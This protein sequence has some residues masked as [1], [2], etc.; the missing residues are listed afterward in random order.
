MGRDGVL[1]PA[2]GRLDARDQPAFAVG[3]M[4]AI[5][6]A[7][8]LG[9]A[10]SPTIRAA[11]EFVLNGTA[12]FLGVLFLLSAAA[13]V[14]I[15]ARTRAA[16]VDGVVLPAFATLALCGVLATSIAEDNRPTQLFLA[17]LALAGVPFALWRSR[18]RSP[19]A[20]V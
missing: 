9:S 8:A 10:F 16:L 12:V 17:A 13:A 15:F 3:V 5:G 20:P 1:P 19:A 7:G 6:I 11:F 18:G 2:F 14:R 4:T